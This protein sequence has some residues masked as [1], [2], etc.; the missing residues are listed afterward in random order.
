MGSLL[1]LRHL[2]GQGALPRGLIIATY[3]SSELGREHPLTAVLADL[4]RQEGIERVA[5]TGLHDAEVVEL[6]QGAAGHDLD[7]E[8]LALASEIVRETDGN[9]FFV[10]EMLRHLRDSGEIVQDQQGRWRPA[11]SIREVGLPESVREVVARRVERLDPEAASALRAAAVIGQE[12]ELALLAR[13]TERSEDRLLDLLEAAVA[14]AVIT[15]SAEH[16]GRFAFA[17]GLI[18][19]T[20]YEDL[21]ATRRA[22]THRRVAEALE[23]SGADRG[24]RVG[25]LAHHWTLATEAADPGKAIEYARLAAQRSL[26]RLAPDA[27]VEWYE[28][29]LALLDGHPQP[30]H[31]LRCELLIG[32]GEAL[33]QG[34]RGFRRTLLDA[35]RL[36]LSL[37]DGAAAARA[38]LA[39]TRGSTSA[40]GMIDEQ[41]I[42]LL[43]AVL[44]HVQSG[45]IALRARLMSLLALELVFDPDYRRRR[46]LSD[47]ALELARQSGDD[48]ALAQVLR[49]RAYTIWAPG[50][51]DTRR[52]DGDQLLELA[53]QLDDPVLRYWAQHHLADASAESADIGPA[54]EALRRARAIAEQ[55]RQPS[56]LW[57]A[58]AR[59][60]CLALLTS[61]PAEAEAVVMRAWA[62]GT[63]SGQP[64]AHG[65]GEAQT[66]LVRWMQARCD[67]AAS[68]MDRLAREVP[69]IANFHAARGLALLDGGRTED[70]RRVLEEA[71]G[72]DLERIPHDS[73][74]IETLALYGRVAVGVNDSGAAAA[75]YQQLAMATESV[76][77]TGVTPLGA[78][79]VYRGLLADVLGRR[80]EA[81]ARIAAGIEL[82]DEIGA[83]VWATAGRLLWAKQLAARGGAGAQRALQLFERA[84]ADAGALGAPA[85]LAETEAVLFGSAAI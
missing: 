35:T 73:F 84:R 15:E 83:R 80:D 64:D 28:K 68:I 42:E 78:V 7:A 30:D 11:A 44:R 37:G 20:L 51:V 70:A 16:P 26:A 57:H 71:R 48:R 61:S 32:L 72:R 4:R 21:G 38:A 19:H 14:A 58:M 41:R 25:E 31:V 13:V 3:R 77:W 65:V 60:A 39:N 47:E 27:A 34:G 23:E 69:R 6:I 1:L 40:Y 2:A 9:P 63:D 67:E 62:I 54:R 66:T 17:H 50:T 10:T 46:S 75:L 36:A 53:E 12:F 59:D 49:D 45:Q 82:N 43:D 24:D 79:D 33:R 76:V 56:L 29:A 52:S 18:R 8:G 74:R 5:L 85:L 22:R 81:D 55:L